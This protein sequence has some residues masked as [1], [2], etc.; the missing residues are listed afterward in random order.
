MSFAINY[1]NNWFDAIIAPE[2]KYVMIKII[3]WKTKTVKV[4][5]VE[6]DPKNVRLDID[7]PSQDAIVQDLFKNENAMQ[8]VESI[9]QNG[10]FN[11]ELPIVTK[12]N[13]KYI[14]LEGNRRFSA[15]KA[16]LNPR[17]VP[18]REGRLKELVKKMGDISSL[19]EIEVKVAP[20]RESASKVIASIHTLK[21][22]R[23]WS[24]LRQAYFYYAQVAEGR[25]TIQQLQEE[26][27]TVDIPAFVRRWEMHNA[28]KSVN[29]ENEEL[30]R[31][32]ASKK[33]PISTMERLYDNP[34]FMKL[35]KMSFDEHGQLTITASDEE[36]ERLFRKIINDIYGKKI[37]TRVLNKKDSDSY[38][39]YLDEIKDLN[40]KGGSPV[41]KASSLKEQPIS[42]TTRTSYGV[43]PQDITCTIN[44]P[45]VKRVLAELQTLNYHK[46]PNATH[47]LLRSFL[48]CSLKAYF[49]HKG[50]SVSQKGKFVQL[51]DVL[52]AAE[53]HFQTEKKMLVQP[54]KKLRD[55]NS[56][57]L[58]MHSSDSMNAVNHNP[59]VFSKPS[60]VK[61]AW[62]NIENL[63]RYVLNPPK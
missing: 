28:A 61:D 51:Q 22:R 24:P 35:A 18:Q 9:A 32:V 30:Q 12:E 15:L 25:K 41:K 10:F 19:A 47:D 5:N 7:D 44:Y 40:I 31:K 58:Y 59:A 20:D 43:V 39:Q 13:G 45:A 33:F 55:N 4:I 49:D 23:S 3:K 14:V 50:I 16:I 2:D 56:Q 54:I 63:I 38:K 21:T 46:Y 57:N 11:Q 29:Y 53:T 42:K 8:I 6:L 62:D 52:I 26:Y 48:E 27:K 37:D 36:R 60:D 17:L 34:E 1:N